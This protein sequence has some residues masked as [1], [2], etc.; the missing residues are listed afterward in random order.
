MLFREACQ[1]GMG[2]LRDHFSSSLDD[3][4]F[5]RK[6]STRTRMFHALDASCDVYVTEP[7]EPEGPS[8]LYTVACD[9]SSLSLIAKT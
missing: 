5:E 6:K 9:D 8:V 4:G 2:E 1:K 7:K 3:A